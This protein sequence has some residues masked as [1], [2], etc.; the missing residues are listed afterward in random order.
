[1]PRAHPTVLAWVRSAAWATHAMGPARF[2]HPRREAIR[3][4]SQWTTWWSRA[5]AYPLPGISTLVYPSDCR[6][7]TQFPQIRP[8]GPSRHKDAASAGVVRSLHD[9]RNPEQPARY[10]GPAWC[11][12]RAPMLGGRVSLPHEASQ[13]APIRFRGRDPSELATPQDVT[14]K[15]NVRRVRLLTFGDCHA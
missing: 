8:S 13:R 15:G 1:M 4:W 6:L 12:G 11:Y 2:A 7:N 5:V 3:L 10:W 9:E 14:R